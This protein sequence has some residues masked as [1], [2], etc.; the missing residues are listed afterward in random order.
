M[1][2]RRY[3]G[4]EWAP[5]LAALLAV[6]GGVLILWNRDAVAGGVAVVALVVLAGLIRR[7]HRAAL[8]RGLLTLVVGATAVALVGAAGLALPLRPLH[9]QAPLLVTPPG[10]T[11][12][13][14]PEA[15]APAAAVATVLGFVAPDYGD[16]GSVI[17]RDG[18]HVTTVA[19]TGITLGPRPGTIT[20]RPAGDAQAYAH[21]NGA[22]ALAVVS[23][24]DGTA[25]DGGRAAAV[26]AS[27][28]A[29]RRL[30]GALVGEVGRRGWDGIV[31]D[32]ERLPA[33]A[34]ARYPALVADLN[35]AAGDRPVLVAVPARDPDNPGPDDGYDLAALGA[36]ADQIV[37][38]AYDEHPAGGAPGPV[39]GLPWVRRTL[40]AATAAIPAE[41]VLLGVAGYGYAWTGPGPARDL[42]AADGATLAAQPGSTADFDPVEQEWRVRTADG[43][44]AW[45]SDA[46]ST[47]VRAALVAEQH[48]AG[49]ALWRLGTQDPAA[50]TA[51]PFPPRR[52]T[53]V[54][55]GGTAQVVRA[56]GL[57]A[58]T[59]DDGPDPRFTSQILDILR[60]H[61]VPATFFVIANQAQDHPDLLRREVQGGH[62]VANHT[63]SHLDLTTMPKARAEA[64]I[65]GGAA[66]VEGITGRKPALFRAPYGDGD[67][68][69]TTEGG[70]ALAIDL[71][72]H[73]VRWTD[74]SVDWRRPGVDAIVDK[75]LAGASTST[76]VLMHDGGGDRS[77]TVA[78]LPRIIEGLRSQGYA[79]TTVD[80][81]QADLTSPYLP[82]TGTFS[83]ARGV[84]IIAGFRLQLAGRHVLLALL[85]LIVALSLW[86][87]LAGGTLALSHRRRARRRRGRSGLREAVS[88]TVIIPAHNEERV[89]AKTLGALDL[90][91][92]PGVE[93]I[94]VDDGSSDATAEIAGAF[95]VRLIR[96]RRGG[97]A[98]ALNTGVAAAAG[99]IIVVLDADTVLDPDFLDT[100]VP[101][102]SDPALG[103]VA[104]NVKVGNRR[105]FLARL[106][107]LEYIVSLDIDRRTQD[108]LGVVAV[109]P[110]A[111]GAFRR[112][113]LADVGGYPDDTLVEDADLTVTL[114][115]GGWR[116]HYE[117]AAVAYTE[118]PEAL[119]DVLRQRR[120]W[121]FGTVEVLAKHAGSM[122][123]RSEGR[124][125]LLG[126]PWMLLSQ[127]L[128]PL[129]GP[130]ADA[131]LLYLLLVG[132]FT[133]AAG[134]LLLTLGLDVA[135]TAAVVVGEREDPRLLAD[136]LWLR[137]VWRP[138]QLVA[139]LGSVVR[140]ARGERERW[141]RVRRLNSVVVPAAAA[142]RS[143]YLHS[144]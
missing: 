28:S 143:C 3:L 111:A 81:L 17:D 75:V 31:L 30:V 49:I 2:Q 39:A 94:V 115:R 78:A 29:R 7:R 33:S 20:V 104:G 45:Y 93:V 32:L 87:L 108:V 86:R 123:R 47:A 46:R 131:F 14:A 141:R 113:A 41:K 95:P 25:F 118:A 58:L 40:A 90:V 112:A 72:M 70:D 107:A 63:Y 85:G 44:E 6:A 120:R 8:R 127:V 136:V 61:H 42:T 73:P 144:A 71:G 77:Q 110:G 34:R 23:N 97:K 19:A 74:D 117:P 105:S 64:E 129:G 59:F 122:L 138:L 43:T 51:L 1:D 109:V 27:S 83:R 116:I 121:A 56:T 140:W 134:M 84:G 55:P 102:F 99:E 68:K 57:V 124:V 50:L 13:V 101:H 62:V 65:L 4:E 48:L 76:V 60:R 10:P 128:L 26:L 126:L 69:A 130:L 125:G 88:V 67:S 80:R 96:Q 24:Y 12:P 52:P 91:R 11:P 98:A 53:G 89:L 79:F 137:L 54:L 82:R 133:L 38:M 139:V 18:P 135:L 15:A 142:E 106:Q 37:L 35:R 22:T 16:A 5:R 92:G 119:A 36:A 9:S 66:V 132:R 100:V 103:A 114:L 21:R